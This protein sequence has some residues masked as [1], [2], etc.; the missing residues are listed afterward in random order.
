MKKRTIIAALLFTTTAL[1]LTACWS[2]K[3]V[4]VEDNGTLGI[5]ATA[6]TTTETAESGE[7]AGEVIGD[8]T[9]IKPM[10]FVYDLA[11]PTD[12]TLAASFNISELNT[13]TGELTF[14]AYSKDL[15]DA[16]Q[17]SMMQQGDI[18]I[19]ENRE[20]VVDNIEDRSGDLY[21]NGGLE[22]GGCVLVGYEGGTYVAR[23]LDDMA[24]YTEI[25]TLTLTVS[26]STRI[27]DSYK[28]PN[29]PVEVSY[30]GINDYISDLDGPESEFN[31][32]SATVE[33]SGGKIVKI[34][35]EWTP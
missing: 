9:Y 7:E 6:E 25:G 34:T 35:R 18:L 17:I 5:V 4:E 14:K 31:Y 20:I 32:Y 8:T 24:T 33:V 30:E 22:D 29:S 2:E 19:Y 27:S 21:V 3:A 13:E 28:N 10:P 23:G 1:L 15:Y 12:A 16:V 11:N 26:E